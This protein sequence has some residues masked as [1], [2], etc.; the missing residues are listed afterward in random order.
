MREA[1]RK[2]NLIAIFVLAA[3]FIT[4][5]SGSTSVPGID[6]RSKGKKSVKKYPKHQARYE[7]YK[8]LPPGQHKKIHGDKSA[9]KYAPGQNKNHKKHP[10]PPKKKRK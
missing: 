6:H 2:I 4:A 3:L 9:K 7:K 8:P 10:K 1:L 5:C